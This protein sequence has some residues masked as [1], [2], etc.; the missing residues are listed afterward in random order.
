MIDNYDKWEEH[1]ANHL[2]NTLLQIIGVG[3][4]L[5]ALE[6]EEKWKNRR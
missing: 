4:Q 6:Q 3:D 1:E 2:A 5:M